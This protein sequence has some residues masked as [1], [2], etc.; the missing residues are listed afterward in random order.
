MK[1]GNLDIG[2]KPYVIA[3]IGGNH[4]GDFGR[5]KEMV[6]A[7][8]E[9]GADAVKFQVYIPEKLCHP[10][11]KPLP[12]LK[13][14]Y[15]SQQDRFRELIFTKSEYY[16]LK[17]LS[18][19]AEIDF[20][21]TPFDE[22]SADMLDPL[23]SSYKVAS[24]DIDNLP[25]LK[26][27]KSKNKP[28]MVSA[29]MA[30]AEE[31]DR[32]YN[33]IDHRH[34]AILHCISLYPA[35]VDKLNLSAIPALKEKYPDIVIGYSDHHI[36]IRACLYAAVLGARIIEKHFTFDK[37]IPYG[38]H[39]LS[40]DYE[41]LKIMVNEIREIARMM[42]DGVIERSEEEMEKRIFFRRGVY[43]AREIQAGERITA[44]DIILLRPPTGIKADEVE[45]II[46]KTTKRLL[47]TEEAISWN[48]LE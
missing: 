26:H 18:D 12:I 11:Q 5:A 21:A 42:G 7:A 47:R 3:E 48:D 44:S 4:N 2:G 38:D 32:L 14:R 29:G 31:I 9:A 15:K 40:A 28:I 13:N 1:L 23:L 10:S 33:L 37:T 27:L 34:L 46:G 43:T 6:D 20:L 16:E 24:G 25:L 19:K 41:E 35:P 17:E 30:S 39:V 22:E 45:N 36:G 8:G